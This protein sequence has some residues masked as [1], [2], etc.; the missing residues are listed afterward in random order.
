MNSKN[1]ILFLFIFFI[2]LGN[3]LAIE[4][5]RITNITISGNEK[6]RDYVI[7]RELHSRLDSI[8][9]L[10]AI[11]QDRLRLLNLALFSDVIIDTLS[12][13]DG[14]GLHIEVKERLSIVPLPQFYHDS[15]YAWDKG[16][17]YGFK[18]DYLNLMGHNQRLG[19]NIETGEKKHIG[20]SW[21]TP[22]I[23][24]KRIGL[25]ISLHYEQK[26]NLFEQL[27]EENWIISCG[28]GHAFGEHWGLFSGT[29][30]IHINAD[31]LSDNEYILADDKYNSAYLGLSYDARNGLKV[32]PNSGWYSKIILSQS[33][34]FLYGNVDFTQILTDF[35]YFIPLAKEHTLAT[36][37]RIRWHY[38]DLPSYAKV[39][40]GGINTLRGFKRGEFRGEN[41][42]YTSM[43]YR[44]PLIDKQI[45]HFPIL[46][47]VD[48]TI[49]G[50]LFFDAGMVW[51]N[52]D[53]LTKQTIHYSYGCGLRAYVP[54][55]SVIRG[56]VG[57][58]E[59]ADVRFDGDSHIKF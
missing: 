3:A 24:T 2:L 20:L 40:L 22:W 16:W 32:N 28:I 14:I 7:L 35:S 9:N 51:N 1:Y 44:F 30:L 41:Y 37:M 23:C 46:K 48:I 18:I 31:S 27:K 29:S 58:T 19:L 39:H 38:G 54:I 42:A 12:Q 49:G 43:E 50:V 15:D 45:F 17:I 25:G 47:Y 57:I 56:E 33:G 11:K 55:V 4:N 10:E 26:K 8:Y 13:I 34:G 52:N 21:N 6:T 59:N 5:R 53:D 36:N